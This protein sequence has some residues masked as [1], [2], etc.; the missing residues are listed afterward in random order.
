MGQ[1]TRLGIYTVNE[2]KVYKGVWWEGYFCHFW[3]HYKSYSRF[4]WVVCNAN[5]RPFLDLL[6]DELMSKS[7]CT[8]KGRA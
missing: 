4:T 6:Q 7:H 3:S 1:V 2:N 5:D 8:M